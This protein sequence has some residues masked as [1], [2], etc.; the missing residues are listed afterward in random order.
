MQGWERSS[1]KH[2]FWL[3]R[4]AGTGKSTIARTVAQAFK[5]DGIL[6][7][8]F[9]FKRG[10]RDRGSTAKFFLTIVKQLAVHIPQIVPGVRKALREDPAIP[11]KSL[12]E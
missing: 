10:E 11:E 12:Q 3:N 9:F 4:I 7:A 2:L 8:S 5:E 1:N 6:G